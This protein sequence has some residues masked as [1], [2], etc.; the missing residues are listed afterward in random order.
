MKFLSVKVDWN[1]NFKNDHEISTS[2]FFWRGN[3]I[4]WAQHETNKCT[5]RLSKFYYEQSK[6]DKERNDLFYQSHRKIQNLS[7]IF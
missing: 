5:E 1:E 7:A 2:E 6:T 3:F 4:N